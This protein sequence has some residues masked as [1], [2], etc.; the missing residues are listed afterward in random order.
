MP[1]AFLLQQL[2]LFLPPPRRMLEPVGRGSF[3]SRVRNRYETGSGQ[4]LAA[5]DMTRVP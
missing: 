1:E 2:Y 4:M 3:G 5:F